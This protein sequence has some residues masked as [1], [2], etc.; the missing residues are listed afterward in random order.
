[1]YTVILL[2]VG[3]IAIRLFLISYMVSKSQILF[4]NMHF[5]FLIHFH[6]VSTKVSKK[7]KVIL[8]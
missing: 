4:L 6:E 7:L 2:I 5:S 3:Y 1:M 8:L